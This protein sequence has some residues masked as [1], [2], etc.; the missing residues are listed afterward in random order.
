[1]CQAGKVSFLFSHAVPF[2]SKSPFFTFTQE[3][4]DARP[5]GG[6]LRGLY[7]YSHMT[8]DAPESSKRLQS[9]RSH[10]KVFSVS[11]KADCRSGSVNTTAAAARRQAWCKKLNFKVH[12]NQASAWFLNVLITKQFRW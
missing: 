3:I 1:M 8:F 9:R 7:P 4:G 11:F 10:F 12:V 2:F 5:S 6:A